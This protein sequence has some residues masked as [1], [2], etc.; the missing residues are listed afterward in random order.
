MAYPVSVAVE[1]QG[2][3]RNRLTTLVRPILAIPHAI[4]FVCFVP[5]WWN[6]YRLA[7]R[8]SIGYVIPSCSRYVR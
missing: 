3:G 4:L 1:F 8:C 2:A 5:S 7:G 6:R